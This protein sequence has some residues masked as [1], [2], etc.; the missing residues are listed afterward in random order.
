MFGIRYAK[1]QPTQYV[2]KYSQGKLSKEGPG[3]TFY[4]FAPT[5]SIMVIPAG[6]SEAAFIF[7]ETTADFQTVTIQ[8]QVI[9]R[10]IDQKR[11]SN[12]LN[13]T[14][15][16]RGNGYISDDPQK[17]S[18]RIVNI[19]RVLTKQH[20]ETLQLK[21]TLKS[22][23]TLA[24]K[25][26]EEI[27]QNKETLSLGVEILSLSILAILPNKE[28]ARALEA[29]SREQILKT[30]DD[31]IYQRRNASI[32]QERKI[33]ENEFN[34]EIAVE[35]KKRQI[36]ETQME[37]ERV[38][39]E[40]ENQ[41]QDEQ[42]NAEILREDKRKN[43]VELTANNTRAEADARGYEL[44]AVLKSLQG[45]D[46]T[47]LQTLTNVDMQ[48]NKLIA[49]AFQQLAEKADKIGQL[50]ISPDLLQEFMKDRPHD[51]QSH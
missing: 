18:Q 51:R 28:T 14:L 29:E 35:N 13:Y 23:E 17:L 20:I 37:A 30:A 24:Q 48:P 21:E 22:S 34:T 38:I 5:T 39:Q 33:K 31:A 4:Y 25:L 7:E 19:A 1:F 42:M 15:N 49:I 44:T 6:S 50:N 11:I 43:L 12:L 46:T 16:N 10:I 9:Y 3:L 40:K 41:L 47:V 36:R 32:E 2:L 26:N 27:K 45:I 8:G